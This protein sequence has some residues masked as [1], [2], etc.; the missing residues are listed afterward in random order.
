[1]RKNTKTRP[2][3]K[4]YIQLIANDYQFDKNH[5]DYLGFLNIDPAEAFELKGE[6]YRDI[7]IQI[8]VNP[9]QF[10]SMFNTYGLTIESAHESELIIAEL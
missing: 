7:A 1:M 6:D 5:E 2:T 4:N 8:A 10:E 9:T 3:S